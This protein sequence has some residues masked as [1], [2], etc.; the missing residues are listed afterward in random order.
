MSDT[1]ARFVDDPE[2][3]QILKDMQAGRWEEGS[4]KLRKLRKEYTDPATRDKIEKLEAE[5]R[6]KS[7]VDNLELSDKANQ[8]KAH[9]R[10]YV[11]WLVIFVLF[12]PAVSLSYYWVQANLISMRVRVLNEVDLVKATVLY[13]DLLSYIEADKALEAEMTLDELINVNPNFDLLDEVSVQVDDLLEVDSR[14]ADALSLADQKDFE[15]ALTILAEVDSIHPDYRNVKT[16]IKQIENDMLIDKLITEGNLAFQQEQYSVAVARYES[17]RALDPDL[18]SD[19]ISE[20]LIDSYIN[21]AKEILDEQPESFDAYQ[22][23]QDYFHKALILQ[24]MNPDIL[25][26]Q[27]TIL[28]THAESIFILYLEKAQEVLTDQQDSI[29]AI[30]E[31]KLYYEKAAEIKPDDPRVAVEFQHARQYLLGES[32]FSEGKWD[33]AIQRLETIYQDDQ[34]YAGETMRQMLFDS[35]L[36]RG[37]RYRAR[38]DFESALSDYQR[39]AEIAYEKSENGI[40]QLYWSKIKIAEMH[41]IQGD[42]QLAIQLYYDAVNL[43]KLLS[44]ARSPQGSYSVARKLIEAESYVINKWYA[45][46]YRIYREVLPATDVLYTVEEYVIEEGDYLGKLANLYNTTTMSILQQNDV[47][48]PSR[49]TDGQTILIPILRSPN[50]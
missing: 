17:V 35:Y 2:Y 6:I 22:T 13:N 7:S 29:D 3:Q 39:A 40:I 23:A 47:V 41:G 27:R 25:T 11:M 24:P 4:K 14:F 31:A 9:I 16:V 28:A 10:K 45:S 18:N 20:L 42:Y 12:I 32:A 5:L 1:R 48:S 34:D 30:E 15:E 37:D 49:I 26:A 46:A 33:E 44:L 50:Q 38:G 8:R 43:T 36:L 21:A 19:E